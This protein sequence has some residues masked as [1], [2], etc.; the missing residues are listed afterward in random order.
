M[1][2]LD[3]TTLRIFLTIADT[4]NLT[5]AAEREHI[6]ASAVSKRLTDLEHM[7]DAKLFYRLPRGVE[8]TPAGQAVR[9]HVRTILASVDRLSADLGDYAN[10]VKG[11][12]RMIANRSSVSGFLPSDLGAFVKKFPDISID[13]QEENSGA[14]VK[15]VMD[16]RTDI[17]LF[18]STVAVAADLVTFDY[19]ADEY[20]LLVP[21]DH[22]F[23]AVK[24][25]MFSDALSEYFIGVEVETAWDTV[26][27]TASERAGKPLKI[28]FRLK[29]MEAITQMVAKGLGITLST[30]G[31]SESLNPAL[32]LQKI[33]LNDDWARLQLKIAVRDLSTLPSPARLMLD[34]LCTQER[35]GGTTYTN[36]NC[37]RAGLSPSSSSR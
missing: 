21:R 29:S 4:L 32:G 24:R 34:F 7:L 31:L 25:M 28:R 17:G 26:V 6:A 2:R 12:V 15:S 5:R 33:L 23:S 18:N 16:G 3:F 20:V 37:C 27:R 10:G 1:Q 9:H 35:L 36:E 11:H 22:P 30:I 13:L 19:R 8:L 14:I